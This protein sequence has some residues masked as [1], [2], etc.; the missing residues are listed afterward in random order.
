MSFSRWYIFYTAGNGDGGGQRSWVIK[1]CES[2]PYDCKY[3]FQAE[4]TPAPGGQGGSDKK[5]PWSI[6]GTYLT[7]GK[8]RYHVVSAHN[9]KGIQS[10][11]IA[12][13]DTKAWKVGP[14]SIISSPTEPWEQADPVPHFPK[15]LNEGPN[16]LYHD[17]K[18]WLS[19]SAS[20][21]GSPAYALGLL[22]YDGSGDPLKASSWKKSGPALKSANGNYG[23]G[24]NVFFESPDKNE[25]W[26]C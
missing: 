7:I 14:W 9:A 16:A 11:Q 5:E 12:K 2:N 25:I 8:G 19:F 17:G 22:K 13:L 15:A 10:I 23:T 4:L 6:D 26:V 3:T 21:C 20:S 24:H 18:T 1:G